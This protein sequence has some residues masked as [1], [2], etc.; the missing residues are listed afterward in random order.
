MAQHDWQSEMRKGVAEMYVLSALSDEDAYGYRITQILEQ[1]Q[2]LAM[3]EST[4]YLI[5][6]RL[7][8]DAL[9]TV[10]KVASAKGP[11]RKYFALTPSGRERLMNMR[12]FWR[13][14]SGDVSAFLDREPDT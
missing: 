9:V 6:A 5:L 11:K 4:L 12:V 10:R 14:F 1:F 3:R 13:A 7:E 2:T 8:R